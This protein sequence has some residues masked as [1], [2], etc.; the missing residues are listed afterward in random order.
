MSALC[1][2]LQGN[3]GIKET[4]LTSYERAREEIEVFLSFLLF[5]FFFFPSCLRSFSFF[6]FL[7]CQKNKSK[8]KLGIKKRKKNI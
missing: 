2:L 8:T 5:F 1:D 3:N 6:L 7:N 4:D